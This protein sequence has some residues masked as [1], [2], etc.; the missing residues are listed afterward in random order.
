MIRLPRPLVAALA[1]AVVASSSARGQALTSLLSVQVRYSTVKASTRPQGAL[2]A[3]VDSLD[4]DIAVAMRLGHTGELRRLFAKGLTILNGQAWTDLAEF[5][6]SLL[7]RSDRVI[8]ESSRPYTFRLEQLYVPGIEL[9]RALAARATLRRRIA[10]TAGAA[11]PSMEVVRELGSFDGVSRDL[12]ESP[13]LIDANV[14]GVPDGNYALVVEV[15]DSARTLGTATLAVA[16]RKGLDDDVARLERAARGVGEPIRSDVLYP[17]DRMRNVNRGVLELRTFD[18]DKDFAAATAVVASLQSTKDPYAG[19]TGDFKRHYY[20]SAANEVMPYHLYVPKSYTSNRPTPLI[21]ALHGLGGTEDSFF[22]AYGRKLPEL[23][24]LRGYI[25]AAPLGYRVDGPYGSG[26]GTP[27]GDPTAR[28][29][30]ELS[31]QDVMQVLAQVKQAYNIDA[32]RTYLMG[33]SMGAIGTWK[34]APKYPDLWAAIGMFSGFGAPAT[35]GRM[36]HI[37]QFIVHGDNDPTVP[38][39]GSRV[40]VAA[41]KAA[42]ADYTYIE[43]PGGN[44]G[45]VVEPNFGAMFDFFDTHLKRPAATP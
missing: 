45:N 17:V 8:I 35:V 15:L 2:K 3:Q 5:N 19:R 24:E 14:S 7:L 40:M 22:D 6:S 23:A 13:L 27:P 33:H 42:G 28:R 44:H 43:V 11:S 10:P 36:R 41:L 39:A 32:G 20:L 38:V 34:I 25:I 21:V 1:C 30:T 29:L 16:L 9:T 26:L 31:E 18:L 37:P 4:A 12:R